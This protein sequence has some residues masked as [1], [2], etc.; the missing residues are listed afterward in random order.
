MNVFWKKVKGYEGLYE[1]SNAGHVRSVDRYVKCNHGV[2]KR[3]GKTLKETERRKG[4]LCVNLSKNGK[5]RSVE[6]QR[7]VATAFLPNPEGLPCV[8]HKDEN[9]KNNSAENLEWCTYAYN[10][11]YGNRKA[12]CREK[13]TNG[14]MSKKIFQYSRDGE[15][16]NEFPSLAEAHR[17]YGFDASKISLCARNKRKSAYGYIWSYERR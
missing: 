9:K 11:N 8:N 14:K 2:A 5:S 12:K 6:I 13:T 17:R 3:S 15:L 7:I 1:V 16:L 4:Y 10:N